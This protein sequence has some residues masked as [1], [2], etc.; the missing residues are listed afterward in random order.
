MLDLMKHQVSSRFID[1]KFKAVGYEV[2]T[3]VLQ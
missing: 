1:Y 3:D 2:N